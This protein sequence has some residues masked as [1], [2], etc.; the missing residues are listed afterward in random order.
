M[1]RSMTGFGE[2][3]RPLDEGHLRVEIKTVN[4]RFLNTSI[5]TPPGFDRVEHEVQA[6]LRR[7]LTRGHASVSIR[8]DQDAESAAE[9]LPEVDLARAR[10]YAG[11]LRTLGEEVG[12]DGRVD[13]TALLRFN[14]ILRTPD[15]R[16]AAPEIPLDLLR[17]TVEEAVAAVVELREV[18]GARLRTDM[19][20][21][22]GAIET[23]LDTVE[24]RAP[25][26][27][28][29]ERDRLRAQVAELAGSVEVEPERLAREVAYLAEKWDINEEIVRFRSHVE[30]FRETLA[31]EAAD[32]VGKRLSFVVQEMHRE[33]NT[34][35]SKAN[36]AAIS[37]AAVAMK[38]EIERLRE[39]VE[40]V[41]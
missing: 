1:I 25:A 23:A 38:E 37:Q 8:V 29:A 20:E 2:A 9:A 10:H 26:R 11:L 21:R 14:D 22:L 39:Q 35:G 34:I 19:E 5:R 40:N 28:L 32:P 6:W 12:L 3:A 7:H 18:E 4:H 31:A 16:R 24:A 27:L 13:V 30:L 36:D 15:A 33:A 17:E 41:E